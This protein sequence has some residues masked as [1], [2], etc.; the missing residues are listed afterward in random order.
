MTK[1]QEDIDKEF[2]KKISNLVFIVG[3]SCMF[4]GAC[5]AIATFFW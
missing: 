1:K 4:F 3:I 2:S 5:L